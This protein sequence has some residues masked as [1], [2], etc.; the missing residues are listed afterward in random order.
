MVLLMVVYNG[1]PGIDSDELGELQRWYCNWP[2]LDQ[3]LLGTDGHGTDGITRTI[4]THPI[5]GM[6]LTSGNNNYGSYHIYIVL[7]HSC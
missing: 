6:T 7:C 3:Q 1:G 4:A 5:G 2:Q